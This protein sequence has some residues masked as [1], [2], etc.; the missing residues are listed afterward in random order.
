[1]SDWKNRP[2]VVRRRRIRWL[3]FVAGIFFLIGILAS[4]AQ[5]L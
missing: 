2:E 5:R 3:Q 1:M 4:F